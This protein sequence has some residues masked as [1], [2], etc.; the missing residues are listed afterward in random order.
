MVVLL[1]GPVGTELAARGVATPAPLWSAAAIEHAPDVLAAIHGD[2]AAAGATVHTAAT[3]RAT[4][5]AAGARF[6]ELARRAVAIAR[7]AVPSAHRVA[8]SL[9]PALDCYRPD[10]SP[11]DA[12]ADHEAMARA[13]ADAGVDLILC[14]TF[15]H[16]LEALAAVEAATP[17]GLPVWAALTAGPGGDLMSPGAMREAARRLVEAGASALLCNCVA[18]TRTRAY[19]EALAGLGVPVGA[20]ANAGSPDE[21]LGWTDAAPGE[22]ALAAPTPDD[23]RRDRAVD[24]YAR[25]A[26]TWLDAGATI[27]GGCCGTSPRHIG[28]L[29]RLVSAAPSSRT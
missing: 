27:V 21:G 22:I 9:A 23:G 11:P 5:R 19:V 16:A 2:Y 4:P 14:E 7:R 1:D 28:A 10:L 6:A 3:F 12:R 8:G 17:T 25:E 18:A 20:Y 29:A 13:L 15:P 26:A 24:A